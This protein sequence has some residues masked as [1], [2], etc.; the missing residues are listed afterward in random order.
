MSV[1]SGICS[2]RCEGLSCIWCGG[3]TEIKYASFKDGR[4]TD[5]PICEK[6]SWGQTPESQRKAKDWIKSVT[7][8]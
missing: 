3:D 7:K 2:V 1:S 8:I 4:F 6:C 5:G